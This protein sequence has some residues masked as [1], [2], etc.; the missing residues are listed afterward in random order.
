MV[1]S[2]R[3]DVYFLS[4][5]GPP[6][7]EQYH[8]GPYKAWRRF[9]EMIMA[10]PPKGIVVVSAH[11]ENDQAGPSTDGVIVNS[12]ESNPLI[13]DFYNFPKRLYDLK[14]SSKAEPEQQQ[15]VIEALT[16]AGIPVARESRG[17]DHGVW[18]PFLAAF[19]DK[20]PLPIVQVSLPGS[21]DP[22]ASVS[23]GSALSKLR[24]EGYAI[25]TTGQCVHNLRDLFSGKKMPYTRPFMDLLDTSM[26]SPDPIAAT[27]SVLKTPIYKQAH[28][29]DEH[30]FPFLVALGAIHSPSSKETAA[31]DPAPDLDK[32]EIIFND[33]VDITGERSRDEGLGWGMWRWTQTA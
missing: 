6:S 13:Y 9:G 10:E 26:T 33:V 16:Q 11:W 2:K 20:S 28:P 3:G 31:A 32:R 8:S 29:T 15:K 1:G 12:N 17:L 21:S 19:G 7:V 30:F 25:V 22:H 4:H 18:I 23:L 14:F 24:D 5:G 27:L